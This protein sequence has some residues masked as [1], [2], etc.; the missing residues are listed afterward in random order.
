MAETPCEWAERGRRR[1]EVRRRRRERE[2]GLAKQGLSKHPWNEAF[3]EPAIACT[4][5]ALHTDCEHLRAKL[6]DTHVSASGNC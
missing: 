3:G 5:S 2:K 4:F 6:S 1:R